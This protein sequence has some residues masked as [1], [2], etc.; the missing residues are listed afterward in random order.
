MPSC[1]PPN[2]PEPT[3]TLQQDVDVL[4][5]IPLFAKIEPAR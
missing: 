1:S 2:E 5:K 3:M 4:R